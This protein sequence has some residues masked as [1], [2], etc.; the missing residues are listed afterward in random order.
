M[1]SRFQEGEGACVHRV[2]IPLGN[3]NILAC[4][5]GHLSDKV[6]FVECLY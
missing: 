2:K 6:G 1:I 4:H 3:I 5:H